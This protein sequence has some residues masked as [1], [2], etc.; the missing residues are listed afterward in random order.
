MDGY[1]AESHCISTPADPLSQKQIEAKYAAAGRQCCEK[2]EK[3][4][5]DDNC[6]I[7]KK[8]LPPRRAHQKPVNARRIV[9]GA[10]NDPHDNG[11]QEPSYL[12]LK[13]EVHLR[14]RN[15]RE[16]IPPF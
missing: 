12:R 15:K 14:H 11:K 10:Q 3:G 9:Y 6:R 8:D 13:R 4:T 5:E 2:R 1:P 16:S 7:K